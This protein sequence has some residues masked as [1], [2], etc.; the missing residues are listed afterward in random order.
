MPTY[1]GFNK[2]SEATRL[3]ELLFGVHIDV[4]GGQCTQS[5]MKALYHL[6]PGPLSLLYAWLKFGLSQVVFFTSWVL[7][8][9]PST[10]TSGFIASLSEVWV[11]L[12][13]GTIL[14]SEGSFVGWV[15][16][17]LGSVLTP[18]SV[19]IELNWKILSW[20]GRIGKYWNSVFCVRKKQSH[21]IPSQCLPCT[22]WYIGI[23]QTLMRPSSRSFP[24][25]MCM[26][27][28]IGSD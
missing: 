10:G 19:W 4:L 14:W 2:N 5:R 25:L 7:L 1:W 16:K 20:C 23:P 22:F 12:G 24:Y 11:V 3:R 15:L 21:Y 8:S 26:H 18:G 17:P 6:C 27:N 9:H 13:T 28:K